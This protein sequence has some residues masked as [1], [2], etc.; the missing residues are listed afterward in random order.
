M[1]L[2][3]ESDFFKPIFGRKRPLELWSGRNVTGKPMLGMGMDLENIIGKDL[4]NIKD[5]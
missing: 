4:E 1:D 3:S 2:P 5:G